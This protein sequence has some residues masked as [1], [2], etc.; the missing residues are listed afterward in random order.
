MSVPE[1]WEGRL[2]IPEDVCLRHTSRK[3]AKAA[4]MS[5]GLCVGR[6]RPRRP[7]MEPDAE[8]RDELLRERH[9]M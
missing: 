5:G 6:I 8:I 2:I 7:Y 1:S 3:V 4:W 9:V